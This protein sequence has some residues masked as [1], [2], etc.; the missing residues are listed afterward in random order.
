SFN[1]TLWEIVTDGPYEIENKD[2]KWTKEEKEKLQLNTQAMNIMYCS[3]GHKQAD[4]PL[5]KKERAFI[6]AWDASDNESKQSEDEKGFMAIADIEE[7]EETEIVKIAS[8]KIT[9]VPIEV[10]LQSLLEDAEWVLAS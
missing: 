2:G 5:W 8:T 1:L 10:C 4:C 7:N 3:L 6:T 9:Y